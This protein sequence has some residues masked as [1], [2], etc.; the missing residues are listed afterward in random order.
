MVDTSFFR[1]LCGRCSYVKGKFRALFFCVFA[2]CLVYPNCTF[3][4]KLTLL[5]HEFGLDVPIAQFV[6]IDLRRTGYLAS[7]TRSPIIA[8][9]SSFGVSLAVFWRYDRSR[10]YFF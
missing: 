5:V 10:Q 1:L 9:I 8:L 3:N 2:S 6:D 4:L 7:D